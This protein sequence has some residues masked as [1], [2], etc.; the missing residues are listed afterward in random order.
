[1][2]IGKALGLAAT[3]QIRKKKRKIL[4]KHMN[5]S[6]MYHDTKAID[7]YD[8]NKDFIRANYKGMFSKKLRVK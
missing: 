5:K 4:K 1:M 6:A 3:K 8:T 7:L 2:N